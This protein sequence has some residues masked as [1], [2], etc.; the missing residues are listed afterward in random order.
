MLFEKRHAMKAK[1]TS[2]AF[3]LFLATLDDFQALRMR[4]TPSNY[5]WDANLRPII[6]VS[7]FWFWF[8]A[9]TGP[10]FAAFCYMTSESSVII[11]ISS[12]QTSHSWHYE[13]EKNVK[14]FLH[15]LLLL[16]L[17]GTSMVGACHPHRHISLT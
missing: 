13:H 10:Y 17:Q 5:H 7:C 1:V 6:D 15:I 8:L 16:F 4:E 2:S 11:L 9:S 3:G 12:N 14:L